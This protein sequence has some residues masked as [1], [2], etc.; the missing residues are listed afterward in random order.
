M[1][2]F[3]IMRFADPSAS[4]SGLATNPCRTG[5]GSDR[6][7]NRA[8]ARAA[9]GKGEGGPREA[10]TDVGVVLAPGLALLG[11]AA[12]RDPSRHG[13][14]GGGGGYQLSSLP[15]KGF[16]GLRTWDLGVFH[17]E[18][19]LYFPLLCNHIHQFIYFSLSFLLFINCSWC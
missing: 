13:G 15:R 19:P 10:G 12:A 5:R 17:D 2:Q 14:C 7:S 4:V 11:K 1:V 3:Q 18:P 6:D 8:A 9:L 16:V